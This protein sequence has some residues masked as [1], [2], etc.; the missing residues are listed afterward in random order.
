M[1][2]RIISVVDC[3]DAVREDRQYRKAMTR[4][5]A[6]ELL[7]SNAGTMYDPAVVESFIE[8]L[9]EF[10]AQIRSH[11]T[12]VANGRREKSTL[13]KQKPEGADQQVLDSLKESHSEIET[14]YGVV[15]AIGATLDLR[16]ALT[17]FSSRLKDMVSHTTSVLY[18][19]RR[20]TTEVEAVHA[21]GR[22]ADLFKG[23]RISSGAGITGWVVANGHPMHNS[24]PRLDFDAM[25]A[26][27]PERYR[28]STVVP[29]LKN[30]RVLGAL[31]VYSAEADSYNVDQ[32]RLLEA[33]AKLVSDAIAKA[34]SKEPNAA[35]ELTDNLTGLAN[36]NA[37]RQRFEIEADRAERHSEHFSVVMMDID[38]FKQMNKTL[39][40]DKADHLLCDVGRLLSN[41]IEQRGMV[42]R[43]AADKFV[44][45]LEGDSE[46]VIEMVR[47]IQHTIDKHDFGFATSNIFIGMSIGYANFGGHGRTLD[48]LLVAAT[49]AM[50]TDKANRKSVPSGPLAVKS[51]PF[52]QYKVM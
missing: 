24:D 23:R 11:K 14:L 28:T 10:E 1:T 52:D 7:K 3:F 44:A 29:L 13:F 45:L 2:A 5:Q 27:V 17:V 33:V 15:H 8:H 38:E 20:D 36:A 40:R 22:H 43:Y 34:G 50:T 47:R 42:C 18:L 12:I 37:L 30:G 41:I 6:I 26:P 9:P 19:V 35:N 48:E 4:E 39:G 46:E 21:S 32:L 16:D 31:A 51:V 25:K 49:C